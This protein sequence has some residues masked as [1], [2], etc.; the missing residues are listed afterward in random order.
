MTRFQD[1]LTVEDLTVQYRDFSLASTSLRVDPGEFVALVGTNGSG[2]STFLRALIGLNPHMTGGT[3]LW[4][5]RSL[6]DRSPA[7]RLD[8]AY[9]SDSRDDCMPGFTA[10]EYWNYCALVR[11]RAGGSTRSTF[12]RRAS[13]LAVRLDFP[14]GSRAPLRSLSLGT[15]RKAQIISAVAADP[16]LLILDEPFIGLDFI[17]AR[18]LE[19]LL[20]ELR[21]SG[22]TVIASGHDLG[23]AGRLA[24]RVAVLHDG[25]VLLDHVVPHRGQV[26]EVE[27]LVQVTLERARARGGRR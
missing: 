26:D 13:D 21:D 22:A 3:S 25:A 4:A 9:V 15:A 17:A 24:D 14:L 27:A 1:G 10:G 18:A 11:E 2:K 5:G 12:T 16:D 7:A 8:V 20:A 6:L 23:L 19:A